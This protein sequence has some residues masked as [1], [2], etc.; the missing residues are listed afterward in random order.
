M[1]TE[2]IVPALYKE[3]LDEFNNLVGNDSEIKNFAKKLDKGT[4]TQDEASKY[5][6]RLGDHASKALIDNLIEDKMPDGKVYWNIADRTVKPLLQVVNKL[7][8]EAMTEIISRQYKSQRIGIKPVDAPFPENRVNKILNKLVSGPPTDGEGEATDELEKKILGEPVSNTSQSMCDDCVSVNASMAYNAGLKAQIIRTTDGKCCEWCNSLAGVYDYADLDK[9]AEV[10]HRHNHCG[11]TVTY[12]CGKTYQ[13][14]HSKQILSENEAA[15]VEE[16]KAIGQI[17][18]EKERKKVGSSLNNESMKYQ[19]DIQ[20]FAKIPRDL[21]NLN[22]DELI[23][24][25]I[26]T[27]KAIEKHKK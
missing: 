17:S 12:K 1:T 24:S 10:F 15:K 18:D 21:S 4:A 25:I 19:L 13:N 5:A 3:I 23:K 7:V 22:D 20:F 11:C 6:R 27:K 16:G 2:D 8:N 26:S 14:A 9:N